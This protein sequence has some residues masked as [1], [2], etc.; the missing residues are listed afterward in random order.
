[1]TGRVLWL[2][3]AVTSGLVSA[4]VMDAVVGSAIGL[5][6]PLLTFGLADMGASASLIGLN[7]AVGAVAA[8]LT[9]PLTPAVVARLGLRHAAL[10]GLVLGA[11][12]IAG[13]H[14]VG[15]IA[16][17]FVLRFLLGVSLTMLFV[18]SEFWIVATAP[19]DRRGLIMGIYAT[20]LSLGFATGPTLLAVTGTTGFAPYFAGVLLFLIGALPILV[21]APGAAPELHGRSTLSL[22]Q[23][24]RA[25][26]SATLGALLFGAVET[27][28]MTFLPLYGLR[29]GFEEIGA[30]ALLSSIGLGNVLIQIPLGM[31]SDRMDRRK[32]LLLLGFL[33]AIGAAAIP[34]ASHSAIALHL[35][36]VLWGGLGA[37]LYTV[38]LAHLGA[39]FTG[40]E[41][42]Q[43]NSAFV[44]CY[45]LGMLIGPILVGFG[46]DAYPPHGALMVQALMLAAYTA[47]VACRIAIQPRRS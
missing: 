17:W 34:L 41:L 32:L 7:G 44:F 28:T 39:R 23:V 16:A 14:L 40:P 26:P 5:T 36:L 3:P 25:A 12:T 13:F 45:S 27:G 33:G 21:V 2:K 4:I 9:A 38:G 42:A 22:L 19:E 24:L 47:F 8:L 18:I 6:I 43:A 15:T 11:L 31:L 37:G 10:L 29:I 35:L 20:V 1:M 46:M 30:A